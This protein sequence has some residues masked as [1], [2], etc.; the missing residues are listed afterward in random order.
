LLTRAGA[1]IVLGAIPATTT[2]FYYLDA[3]WNESLGRHATRPQSAE[4][5]PE[6]MRS[7]YQHH[8]LLGLPNG[9][10]IPEASTLDQTTNQIPGRTFA[11]LPGPT[12]RRSTRR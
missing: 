7:W 8:D 9:H 2:D 4:F 10:L 5:G 3:S 1:A 12:D 6:H 11:Q